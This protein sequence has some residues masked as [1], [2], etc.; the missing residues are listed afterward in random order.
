MIR[1]WLSFATQS[2][3]FSQIVS[4]ET[5]N[6]YLKIKVQPIRMVLVYMHIYMYT[7]QHLVFQK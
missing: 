5:S 6:S 4:K 3:C 1:F 2:F 7:R